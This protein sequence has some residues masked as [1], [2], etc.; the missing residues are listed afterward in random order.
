[1][2]TLTPSSINYI[3]GFVAF[4]LFQVAYSIGKLDS[5][6]HDKLHAISAIEKQVTGDLNKLPLANE[7]L[8][9]MGQPVEVENYLYGLNQSLSEK[10]FP[11]SVLSLVTK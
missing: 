1:M 10:A 9:I 7:R 4:I 8:Q 6:K 11:V 3:V 2:R 5:Y